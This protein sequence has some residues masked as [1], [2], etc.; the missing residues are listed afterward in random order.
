M[1]CSTGARPYIKDRSHVCPL[2]IGTKKGGPRHSSTYVAWHLRILI[3][4][5]NSECGVSIPGRVRRYCP[6][7]GVLLPGFDP[8]ARARR[9]QAIADTRAEL[10]RW[11]S[12]NAG[13]V[14]DPLHFR[15]LILP[16]L[17]SVS[18]RQIMD[19]LGCAKSTASL[20][21]CGR[22]VPALRHWAK[23]A[24]PAMAAGGSRH[25]KTPAPLEP[26]AP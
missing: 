14:A 22:H 10:E 17:A 26:S 19:A 6:A 5:S 3:A 7:C 1:T 13:A 23:L 15:E 9:G 4:P 11:R 12:E 16:R 20:I 25:P 18:L 8:T 21:R 2:A 24:E